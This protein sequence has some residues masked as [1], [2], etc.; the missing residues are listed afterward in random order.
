MTA[1]SILRLL[2]VVSAGE[3]AMREAVLGDQILMASAGALHHGIPMTDCRGW[4]LPA[5]IR[6][7]LQT[8]RPDVGHGGVQRVMLAVHVGSGVL[9]LL[10]AT[11]T[12][13]LV[14]LLEHGR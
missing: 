10:Y 13:E 3:K 8:A 11:A 2:V 6:A 12:N 5:L 4:L 7:V 1:C 9:A 14:Y